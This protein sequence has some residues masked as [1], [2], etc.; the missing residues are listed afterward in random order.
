MALY[1]FTLAAGG[2]QQVDV[3]GDSIIVKAATGLVEVR[4]DNGQF[5]RLMPG[6]GWADLPFKR[7][8]IADRSG[9]ANVG[10]ISVYRTH[11]GA[12]SADDPTFKPRYIDNRVTGD[13]S[14]I[15]T[16]KTRSLADSAFMLA[17]YQAAAAGVFSHVQLLNPAA[18]GKRVVLTEFDLASST[19][20]SWNLR[21]YSVALATLVG[22]GPS[23]QF[24]GVN[25][26]AQ[27]RIGTNAAALGNLVLQGFIPALASFLRPL[28]EPIVLPA[29]IGLV[30]VS[31]AVNVDLIGSFEWYEE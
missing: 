8:Y 7:L 21:A 17:G 18:S 27:V 13:V 20:Q 25:G 24:G 31:G 29:G 11:P 1:D 22:N 30:V 26:V 5:E 12:E 19:A 6:Q 9:A 4:T 15:D 28:R 16:Q 23:K 3:V 10:S 14:I 2:V